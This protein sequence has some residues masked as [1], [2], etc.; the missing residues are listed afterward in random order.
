MNYPIFDTLIDWFVEN[1]PV[2]KIIFVLEWIL[3]FF[4]GSIICLILFWNLGMLAHSG[5]TTAAIS[6]TLACGFTYFRMVRTTGCK[7]CNSPLP[8]LRV[9]LNRE[10]LRREERFVAMGRGGRWTRW[11][12]TYAKWF[13]VDKVDYRCRKC[14]QEWSEHQLHSEGFY[15]FEGTERTW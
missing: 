2:H 1:E 6:A 9:E 7:K 13:R 10:S 5:Q 12:D 4:L 15:H 14:G 8:F 11:V 3:A